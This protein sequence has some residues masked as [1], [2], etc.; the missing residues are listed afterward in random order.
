MEERRSSFAGWLKPEIS[1]EKLVKAGF[2]Y[3][4][5]SDKVRCEFCTLVLD[6]WSPI[7]DPLLEHYRLSPWCPFLEK[8]PDDELV[9]NRGEDTC[10]CGDFSNH[11]KDSENLAEA[12]FSERLNII[13]LPK[14]QNLATYDARLATF[15]EEWPSEAPVKPENL[16]AA[17]FHYSGMLD[18]VE[19]F[20]CTG[21]LRDWE[22]GDD[23][24]K[25]HGEHFP[26]CHFVR[27]NKWIKSDELDVDRLTE[28]FSELSLVNVCEICKIK[29][30]KIVNLPCGH[31]VACP[32]CGS[33]LVECPVCLMPLLGSVLI[34]EY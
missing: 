32:S 25:E 5:V 30:P 13:P 15:N 17:G 2:V 28:K 9:D 1:V 19:C 21:K 29:E 18:Y 3:L 12:S 33:N 34:T 14:H 20:H 22:E 31:L 16:A 7:D 10:G 4:G 6:D 8:F 23:A 26:W 27:L 24:W 11:E